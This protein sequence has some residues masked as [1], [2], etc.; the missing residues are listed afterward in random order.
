MAENLNF[1]SSEI[2]ADFETNKD[3]PEVGHTLLFENEKV[4]VWHIR[5]EPGERIHYHR[6]DYDYF[7]TVLQDGL[8][9]SNQEDG[10]V[11]TF[12]LTKGQTSF[13]NIADSGRIIHDL[14]NAGEGVIEF[15]TTELK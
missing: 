8:G 6:H 9:L 2:Q 7:W 1:S 14:Q 10:S 4:K 5:L 3:N 13:Y 12:P 11:V 15:I